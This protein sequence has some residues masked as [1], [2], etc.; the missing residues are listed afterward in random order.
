MKL[1]CSSKINLLL[2]GF[3]V[4]LV[5][6][7]GNANADFIFGE[8]TNL[9]LPVNSSARLTSVMSY[10]MLAENLRTAIV[11]VANKQ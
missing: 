11:G 3:V 6:G 5:I 1:L 10:S 7:G 9:G 4:A 2:L 8:P